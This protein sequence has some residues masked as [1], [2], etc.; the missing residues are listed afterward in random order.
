MMTSTRVQSYVGAEP[1][2]PFVIKMT[3]GEIFEIR[4]PEMIFVSRT[5]AIVFTSG[6]DQ[7]GEFRERK[8]EISIML[9][10][11]IEPLESPDVHDQNQNGTQG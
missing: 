1:F 7:A 9:I 2:L 11:S 6:T 5:T 8:R 4:H 10:E 3:G